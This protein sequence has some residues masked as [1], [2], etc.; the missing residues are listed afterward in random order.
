VAVDGATVVAPLPQFVPPGTAPRYTPVQQVQHVI[1]TLQA[2]RQV[3]KQPGEWRQRQL[4]H[5][6]FGC[7]DR[8]V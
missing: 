1:S 5:F 4:L 2:V 8:G 6:R 7:R 3:H